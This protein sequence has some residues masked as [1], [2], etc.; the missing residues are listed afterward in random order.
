M[1]LYFGPSRGPLTSVG[2]GPGM[3]GR[4]STGQAGRQAGSAGFPAPRPSADALLGTGGVSLPQ[5]KV[6]CTH[7]DRCRALS[8]HLIPPLHPERQVLYGVFFEDEEIEVQEVLSLAQGHPG[9]TQLL[10]GSMGI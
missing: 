6:G 4:A 1:S 8:R 2:T 5:V 3:G 10:R 9:G 7:A